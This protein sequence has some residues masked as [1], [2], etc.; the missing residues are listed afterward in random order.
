PPL[1]P[2]IRFEQARGFAEALL[3]GQPQGGRIA[4][5][6]F[7]DKVDELLVSHAQVRADQNP[8]QHGQV[9][10]AEEAEPQEAEPQKAEPQ[11]AE[12]QKA[13]PKKAEPQEQRPDHRILNRLF[14]PRGEGRGT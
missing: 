6:L 4:L 13:E 1:P 5:T 8:P 7:R 3:R 2:K 11:E 14:R 9:T 10:A 12:P